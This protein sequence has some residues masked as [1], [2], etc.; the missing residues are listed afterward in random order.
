MKQLY[1]SY[2]G[3]YVLFSVFPDLVL[4]TRYVRKLKYQHL[5]VLYGEDTSNSPRLLFGLVIFRR[6]VRYAY[7]YILETL[8][9][10]LKRYPKVLV[11]DY[12]PALAQSIRR[13]QNRY[14]SSGALKLHIQ[15]PNSF[16]THS[17]PSKIS[18]QFLSTLSG[19]LEYLLR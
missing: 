3:Q 11:T 15:L 8:F 6:P 10:F 7:L 16:I 5:G 2:H 19:D 18:P 17:F 9:N 4:E 1:D 14:A 13:L 12:D